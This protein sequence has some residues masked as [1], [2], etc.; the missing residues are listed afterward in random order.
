[1]RKILSIT[2]LICLFTFKAN[3][4]CQ[5]QNFEYKKYPGICVENAVKWYNMSRTNW[6]TEMQ[7]FDFSDTGFK[8][9]G[10]P[11]FST[12]SDHSDIGIQLVISKDFGLLEISNMPIGD[13]KKDIFKTLALMGDKTGPVIGIVQITEHLSEKKLAKISGNKR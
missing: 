5:D 1:M 3:S 8:E 12:S 4:Q 9:G 13:F 2:I 11:F 10:A 6:T 7:K